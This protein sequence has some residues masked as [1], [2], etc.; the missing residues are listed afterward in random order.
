MTSALQLVL[1][2]S[3]A[4]GSV[5]A[6]AVYYATYAVRTQWLGPAVWRG[7]DDLPGRG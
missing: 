4:C 7:R 2:G 3:A 1:G 6:G 5:A